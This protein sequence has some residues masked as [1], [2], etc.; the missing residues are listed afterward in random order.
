MQPIKLDFSN[1]QSKHHRHRHGRS[2][3]RYRIVPHVFVAILLF[4]AWAGCKPSNLADP[5]HPD[6]QQPSSTLTLELENIAK[7]YLRDHHPD[8]ANTHDRPCEINDGLDYW[9]VTWQ[10]PPK[11]L[12]GAPCVHI[13]KH[14]NHVLRAFHTQ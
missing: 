4:S 13:D 9:E 7:Q 8:W 12:G 14:S 5:A 2:T 11:T 3:E 1:R 6:G 10:L